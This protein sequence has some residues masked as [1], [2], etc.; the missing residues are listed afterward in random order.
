MLNGEELENDVWPRLQHLTLLN[1]VP[2]QTVRKSELLNK[3]RE[4]T[5]FLRKVNY[6]QSAGLDL[7]NKKKTNLPMVEELL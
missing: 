3:N 5:L 7:N 6:D 2:S 4:K 1:I